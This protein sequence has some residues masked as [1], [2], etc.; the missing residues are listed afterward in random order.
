[1]YGTV[2][3]QRC[4]CLTLSSA[5]QAVLP[6]TSA[7]LVL[8]IT[9]QLPGRSVSA[10]AIVDSGACSCLVDLAFAAQQHIPLQPKKRGF[11]VF[12]A[13]GSCVKSVLVTKETPSLLTLTLTN[14]K[15]L[16]RLDAISSP[17]FPVILGLP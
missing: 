6:A 13:D 2:Q 5:S 16:L 11:S 9:F 8:P 17:L 4:A 12:L 3:V 1:M 15:E 14:H 7:H 10:T